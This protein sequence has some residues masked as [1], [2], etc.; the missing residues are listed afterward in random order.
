MNFYEWQKKYHKKQIIDVRKE[1]TE[2]ELDIMQKLGIEV[3]NKIYT[4]YEY[5]VLK[6]DL[7]EFYKN[8]DMEEEDLKKA[9]ELVKGISRNKYNELLKKFDE[10]DK[11]YE[12][13]FNKITF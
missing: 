2:Q 10:I 3:E 12:N 5:E 8:D 1:L 4:E 13:T 9:R 7:I 11:K 6:M